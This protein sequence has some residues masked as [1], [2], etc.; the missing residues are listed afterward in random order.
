MKS[1]TVHKV[2][3]RKWIDMFYA[4][5]VLAGLRFEPDISFLL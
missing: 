3:K 2:T 5:S 1:C 4:A